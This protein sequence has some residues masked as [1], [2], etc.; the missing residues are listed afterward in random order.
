MVQL[1]PHLAYGTKIK[2]WLHQA[3]V[4]AM[5]LTSML[6]IGMTLTRGVGCTDI[7][8]CGPLQSSTLTLGV[9]LGP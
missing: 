3:S 4:S 2:H 9:W 7:N 1:P 5:T 6:R 8:K